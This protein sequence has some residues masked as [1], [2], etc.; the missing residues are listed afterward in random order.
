[1]LEKFKSIS[2]ERARLERDRVL[3]TSMVED[4]ELQ[5]SLHADTDYSYLEN[6]DDENLEELEELI[7]RIPEAD[8][9]E[10]QVMKVLASDTGLD[11]DDILNIEKDIP[12]DE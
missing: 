12:E 3:I 11:V 7:D 9:D 6:T 4:A 8:D 5:D 10:D 1:M 2:K